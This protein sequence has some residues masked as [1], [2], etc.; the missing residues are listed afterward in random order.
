M[1]NPS[2]SNNLSEGISDLFQ[3]QTRLQ[4]LRK[5]GDLEL[6]GEIVG[7]DITAMAISA[8]SYASETK[9]TIRVKVHFTNN[10]HP[11][12]SFDKTYTAFQ[13]FDSSQMLSDVQDE[14]CNTMITEI[15]EN[16][17]N[18]TVAKW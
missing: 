8:D 11:E 15:A 1:V 5:G 16:I 9:L 3:R 18:D 12:E 4:V 14:L 10:I 13:T 2:L 6:E 17:Y 7:Y